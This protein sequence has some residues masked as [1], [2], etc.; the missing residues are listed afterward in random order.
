MHRGGL[1]SHNTALSRVAWCTDSYGKGLADCM[2]VAVVVTLA[3]I[4]L[5]LVPRYTALLC[6][7]NEVA[8]NCSQS[9]ASSG[10]YPESQSGR[11]LSQSL[12]WRIGAARL[13]LYLSFC[14]RP[15]HCL[16]QRG[17]PRQRLN[18]APPL[19]GVRDGPFLFPPQ[20]PD[21]RPG[22]PSWLF[23]I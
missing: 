8:S 10:L 4:A 23:N 9:R 12:S 18:D 5:A 20:S 15:S 19:C 17:Q 3:A 13:R 2:V 16:V 21:G 22:L 1:S 14:R 6:I 11:T 7:L